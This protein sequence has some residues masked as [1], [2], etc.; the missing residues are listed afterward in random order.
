M[1]VALLL[2]IKNLS[3]LSILTVLEWDNAHTKGIYQVLRDSIQGHQL[4][5]CRKNG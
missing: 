2:D 3:S 1:F 5:G 4:V